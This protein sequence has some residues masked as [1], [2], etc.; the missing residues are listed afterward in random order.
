MKEDIRN[1]FTSEIFP[2]NIISLGAFISGARI[3]YLLNVA[4]IP[5]FGT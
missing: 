4:N 1:D 2:Y 3:L 5:D